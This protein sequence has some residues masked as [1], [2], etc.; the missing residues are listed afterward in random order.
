MRPWRR[1][2]NPL[3][4]L[5]RSWQR[6]VRPSWRPGEA[7]TKVSE[8]LMKSSPGLYET[9]TPD[10]TF[11]HWKENCQVGEKYLKRNAGAGEHDGWGIGVPAWRPEREEA[12]LRAALSLIYSR[13]LRLPQVEKCSACWSSKLAIFVFTPFFLLFVLGRYSYCTSKCRRAHT[14]KHGLTHTHMERKASPLFTK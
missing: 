1:L 2:V 9:W 4:R 3:W 14:H 5:V 8:A 11:W 13:R 7:L 10:N 12:T 6:Q